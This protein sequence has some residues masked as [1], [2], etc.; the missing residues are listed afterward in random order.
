MPIIVR[1]QS[2]KDMSAN[3]ARLKARLKS[4]GQQ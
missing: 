1:P 3:V 2:R 4:V